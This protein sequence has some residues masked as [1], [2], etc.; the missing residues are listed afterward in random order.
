VIVYLNATIA[1][2]ARRQI[3]PAF[4]RIAELW[5]RGVLPS[6]ATVWMD[7]ADASMFWSLTSRSA[8]FV[9]IDHPEA[10][11]LRVAKE[12]RI[13]WAFS[14][15]NTTKA[16]VY[17]LDAAEIPGSV[18]TPVTVVVRHSSKEEVTV[19]DG[20]SSS[21]VEM[22]GGVAEVHG[23]RVIDLPSYA[24]ASSLQQPSDLERA[25]A[26]L[27]GAEWMTRTMPP[28]QRSRLKS[29][30]ELRRIEL[31]EVRLRELAS[32][33]DVLDQWGVDIAECLALVDASVDPATRADS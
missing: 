1:A 6:D 22:S 11:F 19:I 17:R 15:A 24:S 21:R 18:D 4:L 26:T 32:V 14:Y 7:V 28:A 25:T 23:V 2:A 8:L 30:I 16:P 9:L 20:G 10:G 27:R 29:S 31:P 33:L 13:R 12:A 3:T 5:R